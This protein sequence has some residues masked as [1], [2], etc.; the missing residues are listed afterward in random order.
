MGW[1]ASGLACVSREADQRAAE[2]P[3][4]DSAGSERE[5]TMPQGWRMP[6]TSGGQSVT[7]R[8]GRM[9]RLKSLGADCVEIGGVAKNI[10][11]QN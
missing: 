2:H 5:V 3:S 8:G 7:E 10:A 1:E 4:A 11:N 6:V 9:S